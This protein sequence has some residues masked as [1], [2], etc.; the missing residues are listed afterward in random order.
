MRLCVNLSGVVHGCGRCAVRTNRWEAEQNVA[1]RRTRLVRPMTSLV[2]FRPPPPQNTDLGVISLECRKVTPKSRSSK[3]GFTLIT[4]HTC[5]FAICTER[6]VMLKDPQYVVAC[7]IA[8]ISHSYTKIP[9]GSY[10][11]VEAMSDNSF[12]QGQMS[13]K[14]DKNTNHWFTKQSKTTRT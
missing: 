13:K 2:R 6:I 4:H 1:R 10:Y 7:M 11:S 3:L 9:M 5:A 14:A 8:C 12:H